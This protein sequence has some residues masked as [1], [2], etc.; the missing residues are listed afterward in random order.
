VR[1]HRAGH[2][3]HAETS[4]KEAAMIESHPEVGMHS[5]AAGRARLDSRIRPGAH[6]LADQATAA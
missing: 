2:I 5:E 6:P 4:V 3:L 1:P